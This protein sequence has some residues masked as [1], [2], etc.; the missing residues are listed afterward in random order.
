MIINKYT[1]I[2]Y[3]NFTEIKNIFKCKN[4]FNKAVK[5]LD[6][7]GI[8]LIAPEGVNL[9][10]SIISAQKDLFLSS[11][12]NFFSFSH[13]DLKLSYENEH[14]FRKI[15]IKIKREI[16]T[17]RLNNE[18]NPVKS[19]GE[20]IK[21]KDWDNFIRE[22]NVLLIDTRNYYEANIGTFENSINPNAKDFSELLE[23]LNNNLEKTENKNKKV[24]LF[25]TGG[26]RC[27]KATS[28]LK[29]KG[30][31]NIFHL[32]GG[33]LK[34]LEQVKSNKSWKGECFVFDNRVSINKKLEKGHYTL[35]FACRMPLSKNDINSKKYIRGEACPNC[36]GKKSDKQINKYKTRNKQFDNAGNL[37]TSKL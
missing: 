7:K 36:H 28:Y 17:T 10:V 18:I 34:Y 37:E 9:N 30:H 14:I 15:K 13:N 3:Y 16:L 19:V 8:I 24:A 29:I 25:C 4:F 32:K 12:S 11:L 20:Y 5:N 33:I 1:I 22:S 6:L 31:K 35:C 21:P 27:E 26:I 2:S 23:W